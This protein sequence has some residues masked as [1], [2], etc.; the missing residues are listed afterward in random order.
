MINARFLERKICNPFVNVADRLK[1]LWPVAMARSVDSHSNLAALVLFPAA[2]SGILISIL[3]LG[4]CTLFV[5]C[6]ESSLAVA[7]TLC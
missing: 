4:M 7:L 6:P 1:I 3:G 2:G 5:F